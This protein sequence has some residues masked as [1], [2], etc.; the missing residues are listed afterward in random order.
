MR[1][2]KLGALATWARSEKRAGDAS[3]AG[4]DLRRVLAGLA[5]PASVVSVGYGRGCRIRRV[6]V[7]SAREPHEKEAVG[8]VILSKRALAEQKA[9]REQ[10]P[11]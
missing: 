9:L 7:P 5:V 10:P 11:A 2:K 6:R 4:D 3:E 8:A 1:D